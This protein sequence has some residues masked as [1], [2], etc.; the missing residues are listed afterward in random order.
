[1]RSRELA[2]FAD[3]T[4]R[5]LRHY[6]AVGIL[7]EPVRSANGYREYDFHDLVRVLRIRRLAAL[8]VALDQMPALL[9]DD[10]A[11]DDIL[12]E[13]DRALQERIAHLAAQRELLA[14][15]RAG[16]SPADVPVEV[17]RYLTQI[18]VTAP[19]LLAS[20][21]DHA[22]LLHHLLGDNARTSAFYAQF[23]EPEQVE[24]MIR[25]A[26][27]ISALQADSSDE[28]VDAAATELASVLA[29]TLAT[30]V[31]DPTDILPGSQLAGFDSALWSSMLDPI[32]REVVLRLR[33]HFA[34]I[35]TDQGS[36]VT[37][38][39]AEGEPETRA[40]A[41]SRADPTTS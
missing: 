20:E 24:L 14:R 9:N 22:V 34:E 8:G 38:D 29:P 1:M 27:R 12:D 30:L 26:D 6:H 23:D 4:V 35:A 33:R 10:A 7:A 15:I 41:P 37:D 25:I 13:L 40:E 3:V 36:A 5:T 21:R 2:A 16:R 18:G 11:A 31:A 19:D 39:Q 28:D 32:Q 17:G